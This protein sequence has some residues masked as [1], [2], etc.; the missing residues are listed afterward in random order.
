MAGYLYSNGQLEHERCFDNKV[1]SNFFLL[2]NLG[3]KKKELT[4]TNFWVKFLFRRYNLLQN[5]KANTSSN[6]KKKEDAK[7]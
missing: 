3:N 6:A 5:L 2:R 7:L 4:L 1:L